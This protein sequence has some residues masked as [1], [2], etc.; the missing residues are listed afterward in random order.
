MGQHLSSRGL[1][2]ASVLLLGLTALLPLAAMLPRHLRTLAAPTGPQGE[3]CWAQ[4]GQFA[5]TT[6]VWDQPPTLL[7]R[8]FIFSCRLHC[9]KG[10]VGG[11]WVRGHPG[12]GAVSASNSNWNFSEGGSHFIFP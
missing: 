1:L 9:L 8:Q 4:V 12:L 2:S 6:G 3:P 11:V 10:S 5:V 7:S